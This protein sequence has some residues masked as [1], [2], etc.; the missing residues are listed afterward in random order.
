MQQK[1]ETNVKANSPAI[2][3]A[4]KRVRSGDVVFLPDEEKVAYRLAEARAIIAKMLKRR[5]Q[6]SEKEQYYNKQ[7]MI[8]E[9]EDFFYHIGRLKTKEHEK[10]INAP[11]LFSGELSPSTHGI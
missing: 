9:I 4:S 6:S 11:E 10:S 3:A 2:Q 8:F 1:T 5:M 7:K